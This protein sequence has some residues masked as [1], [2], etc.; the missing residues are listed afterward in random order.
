MRAGLV[1]CGLLAWAA[2]SHAAAPSVFIEEL[3]WTE[4]RDA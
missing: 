3:T 1:L 4:L 2:A